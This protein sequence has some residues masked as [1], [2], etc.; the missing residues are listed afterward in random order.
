MIAAKRGFKPTAIALSGLIL[1]SSSELGVAV[2]AALPGA[3]VDRVVL[4]RTLHPDALLEIEGRD[5]HPA[6]P[7]AVPTSKRGAGELFAEMK[8]TANRLKEEV[9]SLP[10]R[11]R[12]WW[13]IGKVELPA[14]ARVAGQVVREDVPR[15]LSQWL[16]DRKPRELH[17]QG[18]RPL[19]IEE[20]KSEILGRHFRH[21]GDLR[22]VLSQARPMPSDGEFNPF[23]DWYVRRNMY[24]QLSQHRLLVIGQIARNFPTIRGSW[25]KGKRAQFRINT[26]GYLPVLRRPGTFRAF[27]ATGT[28]RF[29]LPQWEHPYY[30]GYVV[31]VEAEVTNTGSRPLRD[32]EIWA[33]RNGSEQVQQQIVGTLNPGETVIARFSFFYKSRWMPNGKWLSMNIVGAP[34]GKPLEDLGHTFPCG[35]F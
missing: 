23:M 35:L 5:R 28:S 8:G 2:P 32:V 24:S 25:Y 16:T 3:A 12:R 11:L 31:R 20:P 9:G 22:R 26:D 15:A 7:P 33:S 34:E 10:D 13:A 29:G 4:E 21:A 27:Q 18:P 1:V 17:I 19:P 14:R 30:A 6:P